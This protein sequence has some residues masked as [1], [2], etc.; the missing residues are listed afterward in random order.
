MARFATAIG[1]QAMPLTSLYGETPVSRGHAKIWG[2]RLLT[3]HGCVVLTLPQGASVIYG[4]K[5]RPGQA[6]S[7][8]R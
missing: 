2:Q 5:N 8:Q 6:P 4:P 3:R 1:K 7:L